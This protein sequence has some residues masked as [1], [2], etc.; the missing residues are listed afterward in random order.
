MGVSADEVRAILLAKLQVR[1]CRQWRQEPTPPPSQATSVVVTDLS[2]GCGA[3]LEVEVVSP[4]F[5]GLGVLARHRLVLDLLKEQLVSD[6]HALSI[7]KAV[8]P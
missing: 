1:T 8:P 7:K 3:K 6:I 4:L 2:D 5:V